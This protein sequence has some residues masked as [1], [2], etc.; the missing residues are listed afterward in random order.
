MIIVFNREING[1]YVCKPWRIRITYKVCCFSPISFLFST[2]HVL[3]Y[4]LPQAEG[5]NNPSD[6]HGSRSKDQPPSHRT[7]TSSHSITLAPSSRVRFLI[8]CQFWGAERIWLYEFPKINLVNLLTSENK[9]FKRSTHTNSKKFSDYTHIADFIFLQD[10]FSFFLFLQEQCR[11]F[12]QWNKRKWAA[13]LKCTLMY[14]I[15]WQTK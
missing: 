10:V 14:K 6:L 8:R 3:P 4:L 7:G 12:F 2:L 13:L 1:F 5:G 11:T 15:N 9:L